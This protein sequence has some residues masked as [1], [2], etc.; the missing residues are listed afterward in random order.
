MRILILI[1]EF[2]PLG[3]GGGQ[4]AQDIARELTSRGHEIVVLT[5]HLKGLPC[6]EMVDGFRVVRLRC[7]RKHA[8]QA[9]LLSMG[10]YLL[11]AAMEGL[12]LIRNWHPDLIH[13]HFAVPAGAVAWI[14]SRLTGKPYVLTSHLGDVPGG[15]PE[16]TG[17][18]FRCIFPFTK[19][20]WRNAYQTTAVCNYTGSL[21]R[22]NYGVDPIVIP[23]GVNPV[24]FAERELKVNR[25]PVIMFAGRF[26]QQKNLVALVDIMALVKDLPWKFTMLGDGPMRADVKRAISSHNLEQRFLLPGWVTPKAVQTWMV[27]SD[28]LLLP[29]LSEGLPVVGV[30]ALANGLAIIASR[31]GGCVDLVEP[32]LNGFLPE[33]GDKQAFSK[34]LRNLLSDPGA[35]LKARQASLD[36]ARRFDI[37]TVVDGYEKIFRKVVS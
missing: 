16:K 36:I 8:S 11:A 14:L 3:G 30:L 6:D 17:K 32:G 1:H 9:S 21:A 20:I 18:W 27:Q 25:P 35:L 4:A 37:G 34:A 23:N 26:V 2:P 10:T 29:S 28:I 5:T 31:V 22:Q 13:A 12:R 19:P 7:F 15:V 24:I 33:P